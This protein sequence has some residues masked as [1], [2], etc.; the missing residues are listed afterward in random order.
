MGGGVPP[1][2][3]S[4]LSRDVE[5]MGGNDIRVS[6]TQRPSPRGHETGGTYP[7][8]SSTFRLGGAKKPQV[9]QPN[10]VG[11]HASMKK[12]HP[13]NN[14]TEQ[15]MKK[16][17]KFRRPS[18]LLRVIASEGSEEKGAGSGVRGEASH[19]S[20]GSGKGGETPRAPADK[21]PQSKRPRNHALHKHHT[22]SSQARQGKKNIK[23]RLRRFSE[24]MRMEGGDKRRHRDSGSMV[25]KESFNLLAQL[26][27]VLNTPDMDGEGGALSLPPLSGSRRS[28]TSPSVHTRTERAEQLEKAKA[29]SA[30]VLKEDDTSHPLSAD[31]VERKLESATSGVMID[32]VVDDLFRRRNIASHVLRSS[33]DVPFAALYP[34][35]SPLDAIIETDFSSVISTE[36]V[37]WDTLLG[38][39]TKRMKGDPNKEGEASVLDK[40]RKRYSQLLTA[41]NTLSD[42]TKKYLA[43]SV[44]AFDE[45]E[46]E[47]EAEMERRSKERVELISEMNGDKEKLSDEVEQQ[48]SIIIQLRKELRRSKLELKEEKDK[49]QVLTARTKRLK[50]ILEKCEDEAAVDD[51][52]A[53][54]WENVG[55]D[56]FDKEEGEMEPEMKELY[57]LTYAELLQRRKHEL[58]ESMVDSPSQTEAVV[59]VAK[60]VVVRTPSPVKVDVCNT[61]CQTSISGEVVGQEAYDDAV[62]NRDEVESLKKLRRKSVSELAA[63]MVAS[64]AEASANAVREAMALEVLNIE[65]AVSRSEDILLVLEGE[66]LLRGGESGLTDQIE[67]MEAQNDRR[68]GQQKDVDPSKSEVKLRRAVGRLNRMNNRMLKTL[69]AVRDWASVVGNRLGHRGQKSKDVRLIKLFERPQRFYSTSHPLRLRVLIERRKESLKLFRARKRREREMKDDIRKWGKGVLHSAEK[70]GQRRKGDKVKRQKQYDLY[71]ALGNARSDDSNWVEVSLHSVA[72]Q[73]KSPTTTTEVQTSMPLEMFGSGVDAMDSPRKKEVKAALSRGLSLK[74]LFEFRQ[75]AIKNGE[76]ID[77]LSATMT[78]DRLRESLS[79]FVNFDCPHLRLDSLSGGRVFS[80]RWAMRYLIGVMGDY[81]ERKQKEEHPDFDHPLPPLDFTYFFLLRETGQSH[82][83]HMNLCDLMKTI[84]MKASEESLARFFLRGCG[85]NFT[86]GTVDNAIDVRAFDVSMKVVGVMMEKGYIRIPSELYRSEVREGATS[87]LQDGQSPVQKAKGENEVYEK[88]LKGMM[89]PTSVYSRALR[90][91]IFSFLPTPALDFLRKRIDDVQKAWTKTGEEGDANS[92]PTYDF[93]IFLQ[94]V[95]EIYTRVVL[96]KEEEGRGEGK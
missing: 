66:D 63:D 69:R 31:E 50:T 83:A 8:G 17:E 92:T 5:G 33:A 84:E 15:E 41:A 16:F 43:L 62:A 40:C 13:G 86:L 23:F 51:V 80:R 26:W 48:K 47:L 25:D 87:K 39:L 89:L 78:R 52:L 75:K 44:S 46:A 57:E 67:R 53:I 27:E 45:A 81:A 72:I 6:L 71:T 29:I 82:V 58:R 14:K 32:K 56:E 11:L 61:S 95:A 2:S 30:M 73:A 20:L 79:S 9:Y 85:K 18:P 4:S 91:K 60:P 19:D 34:D 64:A 94:K 3:Q 22:E 42:T 59:E 54:N 55:L 77:K 74:K 36:A 76:S 65:A 88:V 28:V 93:G 21:P 68:S 38:D 12:P 10:V 96:A 35:E 90:E 24:E 70:V 37:L 1:L 7:S 49:R